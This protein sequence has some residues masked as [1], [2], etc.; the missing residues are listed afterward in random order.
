LAAVGEGDRVLEWTGPV[1]HVAAT[2]G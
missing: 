2:T 1:S